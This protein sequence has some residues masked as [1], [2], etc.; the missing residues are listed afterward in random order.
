MSATD[1]MAPVPWCSVGDSKTNT[2]VQRLWTPTLA[3]PG[4][5]VQGTCREVVP[6]ASSWSVEQV[7]GIPE[8]SLRT[9]A[10]TQ[11]VD[12][13]RRPGVTSDMAAGCVGRMLG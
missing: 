2:K 4:D 13:G 9:W 11:E 12:A 7:V 10:R 8:D 5:V 1:I 3:V 6:Y